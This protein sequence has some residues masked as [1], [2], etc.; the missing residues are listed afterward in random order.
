M[1]YFCWIKGKS[2]EFANPRGWCEISACIKRGE[3]MSR[4]E[5]IRILDIAI[6]QAKADG[7][8]GCEFIKTDER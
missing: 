8:E 2:C 3:R 4:E 5:I 7:C 1:K 6:E